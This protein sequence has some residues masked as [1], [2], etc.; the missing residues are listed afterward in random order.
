MKTKKHTTFVILLIL[1]L[2]LTAQ[3]FTLTFTAENNGEYLSLDSVWIKN[4]TQGNEIML[5][6]TSFLVNMNHNITYA[7]NDKIVI[8]DCYP[9]PMSRETSFSISLPY[10][11]EITISV[12]NM[13]GQQ[14]TCYHSLLKTGSHS[15]T[16]HPG[17][18]SLYILTISGKDINKSF[19]LI[20]RTA[21]VQECKI[22]YSGYKESKYSFKDGINTYESF[23]A[24][25]ELLMVGYVGADVSGF[26]DFPETDKNYVFQFATNMPCPGLD[27]LEYDGQWYKTI[28][29]KGQCWFKQ[30]LNV[31]E[32]IVIS[33]DQ[34]DNNIIEKYCMDNTEYWCSMLGGFYKWNEAMQYTSETG[35]QGI[36]P[37]GW[38]IPSEYDWRV[39]EGV[40]DSE[41]RIGDS[42]W[43]SNGWRGT[44]AGGN[45][46]AIGTEWWAEP[47]TGATDAYGFSALPS[48]Y[49]VEEGFWGV[50]W[51]TYMWSSD[52]PGM[53]YRD[54]DW[55]QSKIKR[56]NGG[57][58]P[59]FSIRCVK[60]Q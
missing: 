53:Y 50:G 36:C 11:S 49:I 32:L 45:L 14:V 19:K 38:H 22:S 46:K 12:C 2:N 52:Y 59:A 48:G 56:D 25:D 1:S 29:V 21:T 44:D 34:T 9:N 5:Y 30:N 37:D 4:L 51:K 24:G 17:M 13:L 57:T 3:S 15:F 60:D 41:Y 47:N 54:L 6:D 43:G 39:L 33:Y 20:N 55:N 40:V 18:E 27:S 58:A 42:H 28:Q 35:A 7:G 8:S 10:Q 26:T 31:G 16:F 23:D